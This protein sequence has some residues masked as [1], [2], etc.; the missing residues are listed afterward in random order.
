MDKI[1]KDAIALREVSTPVE[2]V[3]EAQV[4]IQRLKAV[5]EA[6]SNGIGL[7]AIQIGIPKRVCV[8]RRSYMDDIYIINPT[9]I[10]GENEVVFKGEGCLSY[11]NYY[12]NTTRFKDFTVKHKVIRDGKFEDQTVYFYYSTNSEEEGNDGICAIAVQHEIDHM[13]GIL[14]TD[15]ES[16]NLGKTIVVGEKIGRNDPCPCGATND[17]KPIKYKKCCG[18]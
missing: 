3:E 16:K 6:N 11:P 1:V 9:E 15:R 5:L 13:N 2:T 10:H 18:S 8:I 7:S 17:G 4:L 14:F 12:I